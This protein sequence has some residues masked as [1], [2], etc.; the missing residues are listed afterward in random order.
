[1]NGVASES[2]PVVAV[3]IATRNRPDHLAQVINGLSEQTLR[4]S[5]VV[6]CDSSDPEHSEATAKVVNRSSLESRLVISNVRSLTVQKNTALDE[7]QVRRDIEFIQILDD[8]TVPDAMHLETLSATLRENPTAVGASG[9][10]TPQWEPLDKGPV[11]NLIVR[12]CGLGSNRPGSVT[13]AGVGIPVKTWLPEVQAAEWLFG[14]SM[15]RAWVFGKERY[16][17]DF[18]GSGLGEDVEFSTRAIRHGGLVVNPLA[19][20]DH[21]SA[22]EGRPD[23]Y[24]EAYRFVRN[25][26]RVARNVHSWKTGPTYILSVGLVLASRL[27]KG[28][29]G[30]PAARGTLRGVVDEM[31]HRPLR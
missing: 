21:A 6:V 5:V 27:A 28:R 2:V 26:R 4:P 8:D 3:V 17:P 11:G 22:S 16:A 25:R 18:V 10:T 1:M 29:E 24:L 19:L 31:G 15:W 13:A 7:L 20:L 9:V 23:A 30:F 12:L 14:C